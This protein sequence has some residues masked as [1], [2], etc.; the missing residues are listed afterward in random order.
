MFIFQGLWFLLYLY[1]L[2]SWDFVEFTKT[3]ALRVS[4]QAILSGMLWK[5][6]NNSLKQEAFSKEFKPPE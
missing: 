4:I 5:I 1:P 2:V 6:A 3:S